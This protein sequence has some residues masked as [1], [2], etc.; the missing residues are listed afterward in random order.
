MAAGVGVAALA[1]VAAE[2]APGRPS[3]NSACSGTPASTESCTRSVPRPSSTWA[4]ASGDSAAALA[5]R[6]RSICQSPDTRCGPLRQALAGSPGHQGRGSKLFKR[7]ALPSCQ[8]PRAARCRLSCNSALAAPLLA[9]TSVSCN[10]S[11]V[12]LPF[13]AKRTGWAALAMRPCRSSAQSTWRGVLGVLGV[14]AVVSGEGRPLMR[15]VKGPLNSICAARP[16]SRCGFTSLSRLSMSSAWPAQVALPFQR[17]AAPRGASANQTSNRVA[18]MRSGDCG[19]RLAS[20][21]SRRTGRRPSFQRPGLALSSASRAVMRASRAVLAM[22]AVPDR[23]VCGAPGSSAARSSAAVRSASVP[24]GQAASGRTWAAR[25]STGASRPPRATPR[26]VA[27]ASSCSSGPLARSTAAQSGAAALASGVMVSCATSGSGALLPMLAWP[28]TALPCQRSANWATPWRPPGLPSSRRSISVMSCT[29]ARAFT[30]N[31]PTVAFASCTRPA[32]R[33]SVMRS[34]VPL[35]RVL[36]TTRRALISS[37][38]SRSQTPVSGRH[39]QRSPLLCNASM[40]MRLPG[41]QRNCR[42]SACSV[43]PSSVPCRP[44][45]CKPGTRASNQRAPASSSSSQRPPARASTASSAATP[46]TTHSGISRRRAV[47][48]GAAGSVRSAGGVGAT[49]A[50]VRT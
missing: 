17:P 5:G 22:S 36:T 42:R 20:N 35:G 27:V 26:R 6:R 25:S 33:R 18:S 30:T 4:R 24:S 38:S 7:P 46:N 44:V 9:R 8:P 50:G 47:D 1:A 12:A 45:T 16:S 31:S 48:S 41:P 34:G 39:C 10:R 28:A 37:P 15:A 19:W 13:R 14:L 2:L 32:N 11:G 23:R 3:V 21:S 49:M 29:G 40:S 43:S